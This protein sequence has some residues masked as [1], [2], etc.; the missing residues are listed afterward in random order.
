MITKKVIVS[1]DYVEVY[2]YEKP[3]IEGYKRKLRKNGIPDNL[4]DLVEKVLQ[5]NGVDEEKERSTF[6]ITRTQNQIRRLI[7]CNFRSYRRIKFIT[8][9]FKEKVTD[10]QQANYFLK[11][12]FRKFKNFLGDKN[13]KYICVLEFQQSGRVHYHIL[14]ECKFVKN[15]DLAKIWGQGFV[16]IK[17]FDDIKSIRN[18]GAYVCKYLTKETLD[19]RFFGQK[20]FQCSKGLKKPIEFYNSF[21]KV[22]P[23]KKEN[24]IYNTE[25]YNEYTGKV[26]YSQ[27]KR[28]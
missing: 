24:L 4:I 17:G 14:T 23:L 11:L 10:I 20:A 21:T 25:F 3:V 1:G 19:Q 27:F 28:S 22:I 18:I 16:N 5:Q 8:L 6:S 9:T 15:Q 7:N 13:L 2:E 26:K 12:F